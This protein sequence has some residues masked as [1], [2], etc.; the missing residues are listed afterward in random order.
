MAKGVED[1]AVEE[2]K[3]ILGFNSGQKVTYSDLRRSYK[4]LA[5]QFHP[6]KNPNGRP[7]FEKIRIAYDL[8]SSVELQVT[9]TDLS[10]VALLLKTQNIIYRRF[11]HAVNDQKYP[12]FQ[13][14]LAVLHY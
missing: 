3:I 14:L 6:D 9:E 13:F 7:M 2:A 8:L 4:N 5:R 11:P 12:A 1:H 10:N